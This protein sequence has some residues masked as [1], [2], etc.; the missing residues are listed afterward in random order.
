MD[1]TLEATADA[2]DAELIVTR[3]LDAPRALVWRAWTEPEHVARWWGPR[4]FESS[5]CQVDLRVGGS[6]RLGIRGPDG[7][8]HPCVGVF[9]EI[10]PLERLVL[11][12]EP[13]DRHGCGAGLPP[14]AR[15]TV[16][17][18]D[19]GAKTKLTLHTRFASADSRR[20]AAEAGYFEG[21]TE[22]QDRLAAYLQTLR[23]ADDETHIRA[24]A[25]AWSNALERRDIDGLLAAYAPDVLLFDAIPPFRICGRD[26]YRQL[27]E[28]CLPCFPAKFASEHRDF[29]VSVS[30]DVAFAHGL[31]RIRPVGE[32]HP[33]GNTWLRVTC[34]Y[35]RIDGQ[36]QVVHE[37]VSVPFDPETGKA[38]FS[39]DADAASP[40]GGRPG[41][42]G[43]RDANRGHNTTG[44]TTE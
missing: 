26:A 30:G 44:R 8:V 33:A 5:G 18:Q 17:F 32:E 2:L 3:I 1:T 43:P 34:C 11:D 41:D 14:R 23:P 28:R 29:E 16:T 10:V 39:K 31:H 22:C 20:T 27:W 42:G 9:R 15:V 37:H 13:D 36:W 24:M 19:V 38:F 4:G 7:V 25:A 40:V 6:F 35:R 12:G 21:W